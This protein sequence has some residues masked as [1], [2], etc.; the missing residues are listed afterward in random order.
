VISRYLVV[1]EARKRI[2]M[3]WQHQARLDGVA[4]DCLGLVV[5]VAVA[6]GVP[7]AAEALNDP[8]LQEY[9]REPDYARALAV[10]RRYMDE[11]AVTDARM[12]DVLYM[13]V[14]R[15]RT[16]QH[17][18]I[19]SADDPPYM[20]HAWAQSRGVVENRIDE[21]WNARIGHAFRLKDV[22]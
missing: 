17:Y 10:S 3:R 18:A 12:G 7:G 16:P 11:I 8:A 13:R 4:C 19:K 15:S 2:G 6:L 20:V 1:V 22:F 5:L 9:G 21:V 14:K